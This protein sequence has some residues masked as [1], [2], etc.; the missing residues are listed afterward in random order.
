MKLAK[1]AKLYR[2]PD[3]EEEICADTIQCIQR[4]LRRIYR[5]V[6]FFSDIKDDYKEPCFI[7]KEGRNK[8]TVVLC[9]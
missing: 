2:N 3:V 5:Q 9:E 6:K 8:Q 4:Y 7:S 1:Q